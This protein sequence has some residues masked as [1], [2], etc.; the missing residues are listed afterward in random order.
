MRVVFLDIDGV[1]NTLGWLYA[2]AH[3]ADARDPQ[4]MIDPAHV[5]HLNTLTGRTGA[6]LVISS[7]WRVLYPTHEMRVVLRRAGVTAPVIDR[8]PHTG[9]RRGHEIAAWLKCRAR[10]VGD[11]RSFVILDDNSDMEHLCDRLV[12]THIDVGLREE[13]VKIAVEMLER[14]A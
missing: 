12:Q 2:H 1:L 13:H 5:A 14:G 4:N 6:S 8:T 7:S 10:H 3:R 9:P 11:V